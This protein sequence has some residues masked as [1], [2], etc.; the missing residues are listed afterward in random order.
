MAPFPGTSPTFTSGS[1]IRVVAS[2]IRKS[3]AAAMPYGRA[4]AQ[5]AGHADR[6][7][8]KTA[9][10]VAQYLLVGE[11][12]VHPP[13]VAGIETLTHPLDEIDA[14]REVLPPA[15][16][17]ART[18]PFPATRSTSSMKRAMSACRREFSPSGLS[19][20]RTA[21]P[22]APTSSSTR[23]IP[24]DPSIQSPAPRC[25]PEYP[26]LISCLLWRRF[27]DAR[28]HSAPICTILRIRGNS[29][30]APAHFSLNVRGRVADT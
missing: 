24:S 17:R 26:M 21:T 8:P 12:P 14:R 13:A 2:V 29:P 5:T 28:F 15:R 25:V 11:K 30:L 20:R 22:S 18:A 7:D 19:R 16:N 4:R 3:A 10:P 6:R 1:W 27:A 9:D 23:F